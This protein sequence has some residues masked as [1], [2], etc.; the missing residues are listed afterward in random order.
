MEKQIGFR[1][2]IYLAWLDATAAMCCETS[3][4]QELRA[5]LDPI[6]EEQVPSKENRQYAIGI[7]INIWVNTRERYPDLREEAVA[8]YAE[9]SA[10]RDRVWQHY[11][12]ALLAYEFFRLGMVAIGQLTRYGDAVGTRDI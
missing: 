4:I 8:L 6:V 7:L 10:E 11:G 5:R 2:N 3:D 9:T 12:L 1:R